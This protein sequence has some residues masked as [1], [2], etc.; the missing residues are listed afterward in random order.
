MRVARFSG[1]SIL[2]IYLILHFLFPTVVSEIFLY[3]LIP[4]ASI[5]GISLAPHISDRFAKPNV[6]SAVSLW[7][8]ASTIGSITIFYSMSSAS[9]FISNLFYLLFYPLA[10]IGLPRLLAANRK[11]SVIEFVDSSIFGLG[12]ST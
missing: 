9:S 10:I 1:A 12:L 3:N 11:I 4:I 6:A 8:V 5:I 2:T 7:A